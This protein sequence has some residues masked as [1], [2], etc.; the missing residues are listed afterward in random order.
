MEHGI[1]GHK[2]KELMVLT[3]KYTPN[4]TA[5]TLRMNMGSERK[6]S[7]KASDQLEDC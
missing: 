3:L 1:V 6:E 5:L 4:L 2:V 7:E